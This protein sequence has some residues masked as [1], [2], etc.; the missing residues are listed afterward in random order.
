MER[1]S[2]D[3]SDEPATIL[4]STRRVDSFEEGEPRHDGRGYAYRLGQCL[5]SDAERN[6]PRKIWIIFHPLV[7]ELRWPAGI[8]GV[9]HAAARGSCLCHREAALRCE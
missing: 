4:S 6:D 1:Q 2:T 8:I 7:T 5:R 3:V 9:N